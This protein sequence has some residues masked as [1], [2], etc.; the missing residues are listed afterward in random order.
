M[1][2]FGAELKIAV[3][4][5]RVYNYARQ[6][7]GYSAHIIVSLNYVIVIC[8]ITRGMAALQFPKFIR[9]RRIYL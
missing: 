1:L 2:R 5:V 8:G 7:Q 4:E 6:V 9:L 3:I